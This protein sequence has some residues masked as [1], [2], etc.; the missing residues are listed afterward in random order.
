MSGSVL[1][2]NAGSSSIKYELIDIGRLGIDLDTERP[3]AGPTGDVSKATLASGACERVGR[4]D[5]VLHHRVGDTEHSAPVAALDHTAAVQGVLDAFAQH[6]PDLDE[7]GIVG[8]GHRVVMGGPDLYAPVVITDDVLAEID[9]LA[10]LAPLHNP[11]NAAAIRVA[12]SLLG[13]VAHIAVFDTAFFHGLPAAA[14]HY[15]IS[16][17]LAAE[18]AIRRYGF[19]G[20]SHEY[21]SR[22]VT[23]H[24]TGNDADAANRLRQIVLHLGNGASASAV[25]GGQP[26][27]TSMGLT[28]LEGLVMG[29]RSGDVDPAVA[30]YLHRQLG[31]DIDAIDH[32]LNHESGLR[33]MTG[34][35]DVRDIQARIIGG[36]EAAR[37]AMDIYVHRLIKYIGGYAA[38]TGGLDALTFTAGVGENDATLRAEVCARL[39]FLGIEIDPAANTVPAGTLG[40]ISH[41]DA[42]VTVLVVPTQEE[43]SIARQVIELLG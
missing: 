19:H 12:R 2:F 37:A 24:L 28:P 8:V 11:A 23:R 31:M 16:P 18:H 35:N 33:G 9:A 42:P 4:P 26:V 17:D 43:L 29:T 10:P 41:A 7:A 6:G 13:D 21:V 14:A 34:T 38:V 15:A 32:L 5:A 30:F 27:E 3:G 20:I 1:V 25:V 40:V 36:D 39:G 22:T